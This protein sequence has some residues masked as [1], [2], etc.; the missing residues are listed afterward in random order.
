MTRSTQFALVLL[1]LVTLLHPVPAAAQAV[2]T[3]TIAGTVTDASGSVLPG[4]TVEATSPALIEGT[5]SVT[6]NE[7]GRYSIVNLRPGTYTVTF[8]LQGFTTSR[9]E[10]I[11]LTSEFTANVSPQLSVGTVSEIVTVEARVPVVDVQSVGQPRVY[12]REVID[13]LPT[14]RTPN[15]VL[16]TIPGTQA[17]AFGLFSFRGSDDSLT[18]VDGMRMTFLVGAGPGTSSA[19]NSSNMYQEF[20]FSTNIDS[21]E[22]GQPGMRINLV[23]RDGGNTFRGSLFSKYGREDWQGNNIDSELEAQGVDAPAKTLKE[24]DF[25]PSAGGPIRRDRLWYYAT[26]QSLGDDTVEAGSFFDADPAPQ[27]YVA[28]VGRPGSIRNRS[29]SFTPRVTWQVNGRDKVAGFYERFRSEQPFF[30]AT[31]QTRLLNTSAPGPLPPEA[32][33]DNSSETDSGGVRWTRAH[34]SRLLFETTF[35]SAVRNVYNDYRGD[36]AAWS[37]RNLVDPGVPP[38]GPGTFVIGEVS[39]NQLLNVANNSSANLSKTIEVRTSATYVTGSHNVK[40][41][42]S[43]FHGYYRRPVSVFGNVVLRL[44]AG[45]ASQA[46]LTLPTNRRDNLDADWGFFVQDRW[47]I[48]R[49]T[50]F[51]GLRMDWLKTS[52]PDQVLPASVWLAEQQFAGRDVLDWKD[53]S[54]RLG[55]SYD[56]FGDG[57][58][59]LKVGVARFV[60]GETVNLTGAV[61]PM[62]VISTTDT[63][64]WTDANGDF[65]IYNA[66]GTVQ[67][68]EL[69][70]TGNQNF[71]T[72]IVSTTHDNDVL[73]G[74]FKRGYMWET[75]VSVQ[76]ELLPRIGV[77]AVYYRRTTG[78]QRVTDALSIDPNS[79]D[80][81]FCIT[82][83]TNNARLPVAGQQIC[84]LYDIK[85]QFRAVQGSN[86]YV[87][88]AETLGVRREDINSGVELTVNARLRRGAFLSG[89]VSFA[90]AYGNSCDVIDNPEG[91]RFCETDSGYQPDI[92]I[93]GGYLLPLDVRVSGTYRGLNGPPIAATWNAPNSVI[94]PALGRRLAACPAQGACTSTKSI[95]LLDAG[96]EYVE[97]RHAFDLRFSKVL[98]LQRYRVLVNADLYNA[99]NANGISSITTAFSTANTNW[100]NAT[101]VQAP[102]QFQLSAQFDF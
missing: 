97:M 93:N 76:H 13:A 51:A 75:N 48:N 2:G 66:S 31:T 78:N 98:R 80:G 17:G 39:T 70:P 41:G 74:W 59:A 52:V 16:F 6:T 81:P 35:S 82:A 87:T 21:A 92:K 49:L 86:N 20:S 30:F 11:E 64:N 38:V 63:R 88:F 96:S 40:A 45:A 34:N 22:V 26:Y 72:P 71:G 42:L 36:A 84:D 3:G 4:V 99:F 62:N 57:R 101:G 23:P 12:D 91:V 50:A 8:S 9:R 18:M 65:T 53:L 68:N 67:T 60:A 32:T 58:T 77:G 19:P 24:W 1:A 29:H 46:V 69:G 89:G 44:N 102:R 100:L 7:A 61:N 27:R 10:G 28:D 79:F 95:A 56:L 83:P 94:Q 14:D 55:L 43:Y 5:R 54:P 47:T 73:Q 15:A 85:P 25:N 37:S 90:N 33:Q